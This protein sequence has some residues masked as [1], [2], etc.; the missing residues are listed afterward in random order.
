MGV[1]VDRFASCSGLEQL[2]CGAAQDQRCQADL[3]SMLQNLRIDL[4][5]GLQP[6]VFRLCGAPS[7][8]SPLLKD[9]FVTNPGP[10]QP[11]FVYRH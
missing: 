6:A 7:K 3:V 8:S 9:D 1:L 10:S 2:S 4:K 5:L 11:Q